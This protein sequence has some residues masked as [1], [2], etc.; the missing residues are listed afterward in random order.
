[1]DGKR[2]DGLARFVASRPNR[3]RVLGALAGGVVAGVAAF[4]PA[5]PAQAITCNPAGAICIRDRNCCSGACDRRTHRCVCS[6]T[7]QNGGHLNHDCSC[8][9]PAGCQNGG[10]LNAD[11]TCTCSAV[12]QNGGTQEPDCSCSCVNACQNGGTLNDDCSCTCTNTCESGKSLNSICVCCPT[13]PENYV[14]QTDCT[15]VC[16]TG[17]EVVNGGCF[18]ITTGS[19][20]PGCAPACDNL[21][22]GTRC[23]YGIEGSSNYL[24]SEEL[25][26]ACPCPSGEA[27]H[28]S[29]GCLAPC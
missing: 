10:T 7:C 9:C 25:L 1:M 5:S 15:C 8:D 24:C 12:C 17:Y 21:N 4:R 22:D 14:A 29:Y 19:D 18:K 13:C 27:C 2:F 23:F 16:P 11:C 26:A 6:N 28:P 20:C 3:R